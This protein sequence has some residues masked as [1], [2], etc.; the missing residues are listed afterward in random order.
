MPGRSKTA[1]KG[2]KRQYRAPALEKGIE[3]I[4]LLATS[5]HPTPLASIASRLNRSIGELF[6]TVQVLESLGYVQRDQELGE[7]YAI[8]DKLFL[9]SME[10]PKI[11]TL[12]DVALPVMHGLSER[13]EQSCHLV[14]P[15]VDQIVVIAR[16]E[17]SSEINVSVRVGYR[18]FLPAVTSGLVLFAFQPPERQEQWREILAKAKSDVD[19]EQFY[20]LCDEVRKSGFAKQPSKFIRGVVDISAPIVR[21]NAC[22]AA[23]TVP[24]IETRPQT[25]SIEESVPIVRAAAA[26]ISNAITFGIDS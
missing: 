14:V 22:Q 17:S 5:Q 11:R 10:Q 4:E 26:D 23:L 24:F 1:K 12:N 6:R 20:T 18:R 2:E 13:L 8:T 21:S 7:G 25:R 15:S 9:L 19:L 16:V 3:V